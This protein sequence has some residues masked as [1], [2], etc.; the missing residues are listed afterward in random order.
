[1]SNA[2]FKSGE[3]FEEI[4]MYL[5]IIRYIFHSNNKHGLLNSNK[6]AESFFQELLNL[7]Y[8]L[9]LTNLNKIK[10]NYPAIDLGDTSNRICYQITAET[11]SNKFKD[12]LEKFE[13]NE[14]YKYFDEIRFLLLTHKKEYNF[15]VPKLSGVNFKISEHIIDIDNIIDDIENKSLEVQKKICHL[16]NRELENIKQIFA[17]QNSLLRN[18][19]KFSIIK[20]KNAYSFSIFVNAG[21]DLDFSSQLNR[22]NQFQKILSTLNH[23]SR[24]FLCVL[25][26]RSQLPSQLSS[27]LEVSPL[28]IQGHLNLTEE[29]TFEYYKLL[30]QKKLVKIND[31][32]SDVLNYKNI[33]LDYYLDQYCDLFDMLKN[34]LS[35]KDNY[36]EKLRKLIINGDFTVLD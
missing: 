11:N 18:I 3:L 35:E 29:L 23:Y 32:E 16:L 13:K 26:E 9:E 34:Y 24:E 8:S 21:H 27:L 19:K 5:S 6:H 17:N 7:I 14:L 10:K 25:I 1:M 12:T 4:I 31:D 15:T 22:I 36:K 28:D 20:P 2:L 33:I 30:S